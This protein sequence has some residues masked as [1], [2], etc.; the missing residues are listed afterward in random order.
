MIQLPGTN[1]DDGGEERR[2]K[3]LTDLFEQSKR[4]RVP[5]ENR[6]QKNYEFYYGLNTDYRFKKAHQAKVFIP[7]P[8][9]IVES[10]VPRLVVNMLTKKPIWSAK[11]ANW[12]DEL[13]AKMVS[14]LLTQATY[15]MRSINHEMTVNHKDTFIYG[16]SF[17]KLGW[18]YVASEKPYLVQRP[19]FNILNGVMQPAQVEM[20]RVV[21]EDGP[22]LKTIDLGEIYADP[23][24][25][26]IEDSSY[27]IHRM[28]VPVHELRRRNEQSPGEWKNI[29]KLQRINALGDFSSEFIDRRFSTHNFDNPYRF[30]NS[31]Y[32]YVEL[33]ECWWINPE[34][35]QK[36]QTVVA[37]RCYEIKHIPLPFYHCRFP[38]YKFND[39]PMT[40]EFYGMGEIDPVRDMV[41]MMNDLENQTLDNLNQILK[42]FYFVDRSAGIDK[43]KLSNVRPGDVVET[44]DIKGLEVFRPPSISDLTFPSM[45]DLMSKIQVTSGVNDTVIGTP[46]RSQFRNAT[47]FEGMAQA[48]NIR[49]A[50][51]SLLI[52]EEYKKVGRDMLSLM[53]QFMT[54][55][56][57]LRITGLNI[58]GMDTVDAVISAE[59]IPNN[60]EVYITLSNELQGDLEV[61]RQQAMQLFSVLAGIPGFDAT[62]YGM[63]LMD[64]F[65]QED[66]QSYFPQ[67]NWIV[68]QQAMTQT[69]E[70]Q[71]ALGNPLAGRQ[72]QQGGSLGG[73]PQG[74]SPQAVNRG[75]L[76]EMTENGSISAA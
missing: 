8:F 18:G 6:W 30:S 29:D 41:C 70:L 11:P 40:K 67:G 54:D 47:T 73:V 5:H 44:N 37:N 43:D 33:L 49:F 65:G 62:R 4:H 60:F 56:K 17:M 26:S 57:L 48:S 3:Q 34:N 61:K 2:I 14:Q 69:N 9:V 75:D 45:Q 38:F 51:S 52:L 10:K 28:M 32:D 50:L 76:L 36:M 24:A 35:G 27:I 22:I 64:L 39:V 72:E 13:T 31:M 53:N 21:E 58:P 66:P 42:A 68:P 25:S 46:T 7:L 55:E 63:L 74:V 20:R 59:D 1:P 12:D 19:K 23:T 71:K 15:D 16:N